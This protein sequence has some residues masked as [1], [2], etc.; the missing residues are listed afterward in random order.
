MKQ[1]VDITVDGKT[2]RVPEGV[3]LIACVAKLGHFIPTL[4]DYKDLMPSGTCRICTIKVGNQFRSACMMKTYQGL[5]VESESKE[6]VDLRKSILEM[7]FAE[8]NHICPVCEQS[9]N[10]QLQSLAYHYQLS[11]PRFPYLNPK[12][13]LDASAP[14]LMVEY[15]RCIQ[16][17]RCIRGIR[18]QDDKAF[19]FF[20]NRGKSVKLVIDHSQYKNL[21]AEVASAAA[22][23]CPVGA[24]MKKEPGYQIPIGERQYDN[25]HHLASHHVSKQ[26]REQSH[27]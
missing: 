22:D 20:E 9:G 21:T 6:V 1:K 7:M 18:T 8:G 24:L 3:P 14:N 15:N 12:R 27:D 4:C 11:A 19:F 17:R 5:E 16:C 13:N 26:N 23:I 10:C 2:Y 25:E